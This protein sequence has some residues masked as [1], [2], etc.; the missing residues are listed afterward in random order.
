[1]VHYINNL[2]LKNIEELYDSIEEEKKTQIIKK[3]ILIDHLIENRISSNN[4]NR[5]KYNKNRAIKKINSMKEDLLEKKSFFQNYIKQ[6]ERKQKEIEETIFKNNIKLNEYYNNYKKSKN[7][8]KEIKIKL[9]QGN[10]LNNYDY[11]LI[12]YNIL[13][14]QT[15]YKKLQRNFKI[16]QQ[17]SV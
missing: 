3:Q 5:K 17:C 12:K 7:N 8:C 10:N 4:F 14:K 6:I 15:Q 11:Y 9:K 13:K 1:M 2:Y 16:K